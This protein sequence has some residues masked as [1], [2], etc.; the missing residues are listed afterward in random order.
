MKHT[1]ISFPGSAGARSNKRFAAVSLAP[2]AFAISGLAGAQDGESKVLEEITVYAEKRSAD[3]Q[4]TSIAVATIS[5]DQAIKQGLV[6]MGDLVKDMIGVNIQDVGEGSAVNVRGLGW[7]MPVDVG[8]NAVAMYYDGSANTS[9]QAAI[10]GFYDMERMEV[11]RGPQGTLYGRNATAGVVHVYTRSPVPDEMEGYALAEFGNYSHSR[12]EGAV[13]IPLTEH[14]A[15]RIAAS[16]IDRDG[17]MSTGSGDIDGTAVRAKYGY[18][19]NDKFLLT[20]IGEYNDLGGVSPDINTPAASYDAGDPYVSSRVDPNQKYEF[21]TERYS[22]IVELDAGPGR[23]TFTPAYS[24]SERGGTT[25]IPFP[26][27][28]ALMNYGDDVLEQTSAELRYASLAESEIQWV[29]GLYYYDREQEQSVAIGPCS[30]AGCFR[31]ATSEAVFGQ[32]TV[33]VSDSFRVIVGGRYSE[34]ESTL[35]QRNDPP[36]T[37][38][39]DAAET[40]DNFTWKLGTEL[41]LSEDAMAYATIATGTRPGGFN[42]GVNVDSPTFA[43]EKLTSYEV[44]IKSRWLED[45]LQVNAAAFYFDYQDYQTTDAAGDP[46]LDPANF[47]VQFF[48]AADARNLGVELETVALIGDATRINAGVSYLDAEYTSEFELHEN[49]FSDPINLKNEPLPRTPNWTVKLGIDHDF[50]LGDF[51]VLTLAAAM[52]YLDDHKG[53]AIP[54]PVTAIDSYSVIDLNASFSPNEGNWS[55]NLWAKNAD[56]EVYKMG[57]STNDVQAGP[58]RMYGASFRY[59]F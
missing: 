54:T 6:N 20:L 37:P 1:S 10:F 26:P 40:F 3:L 43:E 33:P 56:E 14:S 57:A 28:G 55:I 13:N 17:Y 25:F 52:R 45:T 4:N 16:D 36:G 9:Q 18:I 34:D 30:G 24:E 58:P 19:P 32:A 22:A 23:I 53:A 11:L 12:Y 5:G 29:V 46:F 44:G 41:D 21:T 48:N 51:G 59:D 49:P 47:Y 35:I 2:L 39:A 15:V 8:E 42:T 27:P 50:R 31:G 38:F 7:D